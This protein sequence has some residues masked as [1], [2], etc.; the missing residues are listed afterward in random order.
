V[1]LSAYITDVGMN[2]AHDSVIGVEKEIIFQK[3][4]TGMPLRYESANSGLQVNAVLIELIERIR[5]KLK[6]CLNY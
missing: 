3:L 1:L 6:S 2:G 4:I 5:R